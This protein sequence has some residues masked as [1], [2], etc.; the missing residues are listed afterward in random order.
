VF[1]FVLSAGAVFS[2]ESLE[3][4]V[5]TGDQ[6]EDELG[7]PSLGALPRPDRARWA[8]RAPQLQDYVL[9]KPLSRHAEVLRTIHAA[10]LFQKRKSAD[11][12]V[13]LVTSA[14]P[15]EGKSTFV[16]A[17]ARV[18]AKAGHRVLAVDCD[19]HHPNLHNLFGVTIEKEVDE[20]LAS[21]Q[22]RGVLVQ[23]DSASGA[24]VIPTA[25][26]ADQTQPLSVTD[27]LKSY[28]DALRRQ[29]DLIL[30]DTPPV[31]LFADATE[32]AQL[33][34]HCIL[35]VQWHETKRVAVKHALKALTRVNANM[36]GAVL[37]NVDSRRYSKYDYG[38]GPYDHGEYR[39]YYR[40]QD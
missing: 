16:C 23:L 25:A 13:V 6:I 24:E 39:K 22:R 29:Y 11:A 21:D 40:D 27:R 1:A 14:L 20:Y 33:S 37:T 18:L 31:L 15:G 30:V 19:S 2:V 5:R 3:Y 28:L 12:H 8:R 26:K 32:L 35:V 36:A 38:S 9:A 17:L 10:L 7:L 4:R 34:D